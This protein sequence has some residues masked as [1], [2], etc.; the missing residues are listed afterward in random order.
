MPES[1]SLTLYNSSIMP[2]AI[3]SIF[4]MGAV[5]E[6]AGNTAPKKGN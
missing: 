1:A 5:V 6:P 2:V 4:K 3:S